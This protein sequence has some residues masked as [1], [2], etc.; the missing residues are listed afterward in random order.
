[1][2]VAQ[3]MPLSLPRSVGLLPAMYG[4]TNDNRLRRSDRPTRKAQRRRCRPSTGR[5]PTPSRPVGKRA[6]AVAER[7][8]IV[9]LVFCAHLNP[10]LCVPRG[11]NQE[12]ILLRP[13]VRVAYTVLIMR[14]AECDDAPARILLDGTD[15]NT[16]PSTVRAYLRGVALSSA[17]RTWH[18][19]TVSLPFRIPC[20]RLGRF[21]MRMRTCVRDAISR[22]APMTDYA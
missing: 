5:I 19:P 1:M 13:R 15:D 7:V 20:G 2:L 4:D 18:A 3:K 16:A 17:F 6:R 12:Y 11:L 10:S 21:G 9:A 14:L 22:I 8:K